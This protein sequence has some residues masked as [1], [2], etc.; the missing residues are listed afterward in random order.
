MPLKVYITNTTPLA[1]AN[2]SLCQHKL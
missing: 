1:R 2:I